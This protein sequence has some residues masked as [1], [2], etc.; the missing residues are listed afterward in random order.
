MFLEMKENYQLSN[1]F[2]EVIMTEILL[3]NI[4]YSPKH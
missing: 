4:I 1:H 3:L 2:N